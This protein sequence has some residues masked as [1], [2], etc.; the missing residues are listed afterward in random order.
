MSKENFDYTEHYKKFYEAWEK[1][2]SEAMDMWKKNPLAKGE[3]AESKEDY[4][5]IAQYKKFYDTWEKSSSEVLEKWVNS[6]L[7]AANIG[8]AV[9]K[10]SEFKKYFDEAVE[11]TLKNMRFPTKSDIDRVL[12]S[13][14]NLEAKVNDLLDK[15]DD[16]SKPA[17][18]T[19]K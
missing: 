2:M 8:K 11:K 1:T 13:I 19:K 10:S 17:R 14:N 7:F 4:D 9:E 12:S 15:M 16:I 18:T 6:P 5:P 3:A